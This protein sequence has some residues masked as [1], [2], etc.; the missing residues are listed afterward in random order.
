[1]F[2]DYIERRDRVRAVRFTHPDQVTDLAEVFN[3]VSYSFETVS[4]GSWAGPWR[5]VIVG[6]PDAYSGD[7]TVKNIVINYGDYVIEGQNY[8]TGSYGGGYSG[9]HVMT[10]EEFRR[11]EDVDDVRRFLGIE[12]NDA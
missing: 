3:P 4:D 8:N 1:M 2:R 12:V 9:Y 5:I 10:R 6:R 11:F 7:S